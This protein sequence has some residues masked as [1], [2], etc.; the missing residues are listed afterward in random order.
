MLIL[1]PLTIL[2]SLF[3]LLLVGP[4]L[5]GL[6][7]PLLS[8]SSE[9]AHENVRGTF[10]LPAAFFVFSPNFLGMWK[11]VTL[12]SKDRHHEIHNREFRGLLFIGCYK[13]IL[14][15]FLWDSQNQ[16]QPCHCQLGHLYPYRIISTPT[17]SY[18]ASES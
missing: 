17:L 15:Q 13:I 16:S 10:A 11:R 4:L 14:L 8:T 7:W 1:L 6:H 12:I 9:C 18:P 5:F 3:V 2:L